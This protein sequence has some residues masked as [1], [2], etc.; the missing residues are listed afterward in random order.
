MGD[1]TSPGGRTTRLNDSSLSGPWDMRFTARS[2]TGGARTFCSVDQYTVSGRY[3]R[4]RMHR[5]GSAGY[6]SCPPES[7][8]VRSA[9]EKAVRDRAPAIRCCPES[10]SAVGRGGSHHDSPRSALVG[11]LRLQF[12]RSARGLL[13]LQNK[14]AGCGPSFSFVVLPGQRHAWNS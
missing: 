6:P 9:R 13:G 3:V 12:C 1:G 4:I 2:G 5:S 14:V 10:V 7:G 11:T 8:A